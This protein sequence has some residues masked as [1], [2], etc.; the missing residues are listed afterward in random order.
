VLRQTRTLPD[1]LRV[2]RSPSGQ[3]RWARPALLTIAALAGLAYAWGWSSPELQLYYA[4]A[5]RSMSASWHDFLF[6]AFDPSGTVTVD[7][8]P[9]ALWPQALLVRVVGFHVWALILP[10]VLEGVVTILVLYRAVTRM[11][12]PLAGLTA[13]VVLAATP[14]TVALGRGN[15]SDSLLIMLSVLA[16]DATCAAILD[17]RLRTLVV[18]GVWVGLAFQAKMMQAWLVLPA[19][20]VAYAL[21]APGRLA[22]RLRNIAVA[23][24]AC[25]AVSLSWMAAV[26]LVSAHDRPY[27]DGTADNSLF[28][29]AFYYNGIAR[30]GHGDVLSSAGRPEPFL[31]ELSHVGLALETIDAMIAPGWDRLLSGPF[32]RDVAWL[33]PAALLAA[34]GVA[35]ARRRGA[36]TDQ[37]RAGVV[38]WGLWL[39]TLFAFFS[40]GAYLNSYY[41]AALAPAIAAL[42]GIGI[43]LASQR[44][45]D[46]STRVVLALTVLASGGYGA[47]LL[48]GGDEVPGWLIPAAVVVGVLGAVAIFTLGRL[49]GARSQVGGW[50]VALTAACALFVPAVSAALVVKRESG[51][52]AAPYQRPVPGSSGA[53]SPQAFS[54]DGEVVEE[55]ASHYETPIPFGADT[56]VLAARYILATGQEILPIGGLLGAAPVPSLAQ[57]RSD[58]SSGELHGIFIPVQPHSHDA[59]VQWIYAHCARGP[60]LPGPTPQ[61]TF[62]FYAC[63]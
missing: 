46:P 54:R 14:V 59:R 30:L 60:T 18:A 38:V 57:L 23:G 58:I 25:V 24:C 28:S 41:L 48:G 13:A 3:P 8:L 45:A 32:A 26:S 63:M 31:V 52:F 22:T 19:L 6:G 10:Q 15:V 20:A 29:Q 56:S 44:R 27:V 50:L 11:A 40:E 47:Y 61:V 17:G 33:L 5:A 51:P 42:C 37:L 16:A 12:G 36:R 2:W 21:A 55:A 9:G 62:A 43:A 49:P 1:A 34:L 35:L 53:A 4:A 7:K 39:A